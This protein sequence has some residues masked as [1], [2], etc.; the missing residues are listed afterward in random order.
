MIGKKIKKF[1]T[2]TLVGNII[3]KVAFGGIVK[4]TE[5]RTTRTNEGQVDYK[6]F[7]L[8]LLTSSI[9]VILVVALLFGWLDLATL[10]ELAKILIP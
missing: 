3:D 8:D 6:E 1:L 5:E 9:P 2:K 10:K 7:I 4:T